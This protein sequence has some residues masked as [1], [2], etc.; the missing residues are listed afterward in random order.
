VMQRTTGKRRVVEDRLAAPMFALALLFLILL[1][2][3]INLMRSSQEIRWDQLSVQVVAGGLLL[4]WLVFLVE[5]AVRYLLGPRDRRTWK[6][7]AWCVASG[8]LPPLRLAAWSRTRPHHIWLPRVGWQ[9]IDFDLQ[10][11]LERGFSGPMLVMALLIL[12][13]LAIEYF[14]AAALDDSPLL[15]AVLHIGIGLVWVAFTIE[16]IIRIATAEKKLGYAFNHWVDLAV[17]LLPMVEFMPLLRL[18]RATR[19]MRLTTLAR[20]G[21]Y[22]RL[23]GVAGKG[24]RGMVVLGVMQR[25]WS[26]S[27]QARIGRLNGDLEEK[28]K[29]IRELEREADYYR[30][31]I[32]AIEREL[33]ERGELPESDA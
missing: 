20:M 31:R 24:W 17:V 22:Y 33:A 4:L 27:P 11:T 6:A 12:P 15:R 28:L 5:A 10:K 32:A 7:L 30:R 3:A 18:L 9:K 13:L 23:Y 19:L 14:W 16:F 29:E 1:A 21:K 8:L 25:L 26:R 2:T